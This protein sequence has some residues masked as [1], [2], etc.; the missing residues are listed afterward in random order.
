MRTDGDLKVVVTISASINVH[1]TESS[2]KGHSLKS[3]LWYLKL[4]QKLLRKNFYSCKVLDDL[5]ILFSYRCEMIFKAFLTSFQKVEELIKL[6]MH[7][8][9]AIMF[10]CKFCNP[11]LHSL[12]I[13]TINSKCTPSDI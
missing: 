1:P 13:V 2:R 4:I 12:N 6:L 8:L 11:S 7:D 9:C 10:I 3:I 5:N